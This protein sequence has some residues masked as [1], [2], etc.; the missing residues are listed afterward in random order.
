MRIISK[1]QPNEYP[2]YAEMYIKLLPND[3][4]ILKY[5]R[6][7]GKEAKQ[8]FLSV[9]KNKL[10]FRYAPGKWTIKEILL[11]MI[12]DE[13]IYTYRALRI[14]RADT[15]PLP[16][17]E[18]PY[19]VYSKANERTITSLVQEFLTVRK[20]TLSLFTNPP[21][22]AMMRGGTA[23]NHY[24]TVRALL[25]HLGGHELHHRNIIKEKYLEQ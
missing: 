19:A 8:F 7:N 1:P 6:D 23:N 22:E 3:G 16:G 4:L 25:Y 18:D 11:H 17:F 15:T 14:A 20:A 24:V 12:D 5:L 2:A 21:E 10:E 13:R 9:P